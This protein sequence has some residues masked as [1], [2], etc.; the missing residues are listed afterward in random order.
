MNGRIIHE[1]LSPI[2]FM[3]ACVG[4]IAIAHHA[5]GCSPRPAEDPRAQ[6][7]AVVLTVA[8]GVKAADVACASIARAKRDATLAR[9]CDKARDEAAESLKAAE[10]ALDAE[11]AARAG[12]VPC[13]VA[14]A[15]SSASRLAGLIEHAGGKL[16]KA[17]LDGLQLAP[18]LAGGCHG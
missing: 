13:M 15:V 1:A 14:A 9:E 8:D 17:M 3:L 12:D 16:P 5:C 18:M 10:D 11:D 6:R 4:V 2:L 7:R